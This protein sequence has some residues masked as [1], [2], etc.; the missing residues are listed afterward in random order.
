M[1][2]ELFLNFIRSGKLPHAFIH[3]D[4]DIYS[5]MGSVKCWEQLRRMGINL[6]FIPL[7]TWALLASS[8]PETGSLPG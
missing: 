1:M 7:R 5:P 3:G 8:C 6:I 4:K 2:Y